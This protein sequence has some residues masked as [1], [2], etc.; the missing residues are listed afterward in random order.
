MSLN[1]VHDLF[2]KSDTVIPIKGYPSNYIY[3]DNDKKDIT[4]YMLIN[5]NIINLYD[6]FA[7]INT[8]D[9]ETSL[10]I[11]LVHPQ[12]TLR[13]GT[14]LLELSKVFPESC[15]LI[16]SGGNE[17]SGFVILKTSYRHIDTDRWVLMFRGARLYR[18]MLVNILVY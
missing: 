4:G 9:F 7:T 10:S 5:G 15:K 1:D 16:E 12:I 6:D 14:T 8:I 11:T 3:I 13:K 18:I 17:W 2:G